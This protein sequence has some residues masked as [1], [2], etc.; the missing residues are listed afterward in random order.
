MKNQPHKKPLKKTFKKLTILVFKIMV[1][2]TLGSP[3]DFWV[4]NIKV[5]FFSYIFLKVIHIY[6]LLVKEG[7]DL[8]SY[9]DSS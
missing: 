1:L 6:I 3:K 4:D 9:L 5:Y 7:E 8:D 2:G